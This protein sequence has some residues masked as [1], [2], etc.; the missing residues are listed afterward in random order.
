[1]CSISGEFILKI[2]MN[3]IYRIFSG[4]QR[5]S[6][7]KVLVNSSSSGRVVALVGSGIRGEFFSKILMSYV[8]KVFS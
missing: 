2:L 8:H 7:C 6:G 4:Y 1:V 5:G 3:Y